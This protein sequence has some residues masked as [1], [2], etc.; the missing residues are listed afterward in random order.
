MNNILYIILFGVIGTI[1]SF[2]IIAWGI[3]IVKS[4]LI[5][6]EYF[7]YITSL[8]AKEILLFSS[9]LSCTEIFNTI[10]FLKPHVQAKIFSN[11]TTETA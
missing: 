2:V 10:P 8:S 5:F 1:I 4:S 11:R 7:S 6:E 9:V 3:I